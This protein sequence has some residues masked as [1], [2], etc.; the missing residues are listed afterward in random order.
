MA[1]YREGVIVEN[2]KILV[3]AVSV[4]GTVSATG[5]HPVPMPALQVV[6]GAIRAVMV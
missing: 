3:L 6:Q 2:G 4:S 5:F 1:N